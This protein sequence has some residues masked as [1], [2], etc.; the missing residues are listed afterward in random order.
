M[1][2]LWQRVMITWT[3]FQLSVVNEAV[4]QWQKRLDAVMPVFVHKKET[5]DSCSDI[6]CRVFHGCIKRIESLTFLTSSYCCKLLRLFANFTRCS[7]S[8]KARL[9]KN[10]STFPRDVARQI[11]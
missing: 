7:Y 3:G 5:S 4:H 6:V 8:F 11:L 10:C 2:D 1:G 9:T